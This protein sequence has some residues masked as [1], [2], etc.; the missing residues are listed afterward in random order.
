MYPPRRRAPLCNKFTTAMSEPDDLRRR[1]PDLFGSRPLGLSHPGPLYEKALAARAQL[2]AA[3]SNATTTSSSSS[4]SGSSCGFPASPR[5][6]SS[7]SSTTDLSSKSLFGVSDW[8]FPLAPGREKSL[9]EDWSFG[10][11]SK[12]TKKEELPWA[13]EEEQEFTAKFPN[14]NNNIN[15]NANSSLKLPPSINSSLSALEKAQARLRGETSLFNNNSNTNNDNNDIN[16]SNMPTPSSS[17]QKPSTGHLQFGQFLTPGDGN[18]TDEDQSDAS[19]LSAQEKPLTGIARRRK[20]SSAARA[21]KDKIAAE[22]V[23]FEQMNGKDYFRKL[24]NNYLKIT[25]FFF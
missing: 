1:N 7:C 8:P 17:I 19:N 10:S 21:L 9:K 15:S 16:D 18:N 12:K 5:L 11:L 25:K 2:Q 13:I 24:K 6:K 23:D 3:S 22:T 4:S 20:K 14:A